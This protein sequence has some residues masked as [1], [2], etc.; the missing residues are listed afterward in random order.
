MQHTSLMSLDSR[1]AHDFHA[2]TFPFTC[3]LS[4]AP[5]IAF[6]QQALSTQHPIKE[7]IA[8]MVQDQVHGGLGV[9]SRSPLASMYLHAREARIYDGPDEVHRMVVS[10]RILRAFRDGGAY[11]FA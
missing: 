5:L 1:F 2:I 7:A 3:Q 8:R 4:L 6:W 9:T 11:E 10:R